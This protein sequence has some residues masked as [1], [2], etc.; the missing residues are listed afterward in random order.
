MLMSVSSLAINQM[1]HAICHIRV[2]VSIET[3]EIDLDVICV[4]ICKLAI[5]VQG[6]S[7]SVRIL[8]RVQQDIR[9]IILVVASSRLH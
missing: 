9:P 6:K 7:R 3:D 1:S 4:P 2:W 5:V 8:V